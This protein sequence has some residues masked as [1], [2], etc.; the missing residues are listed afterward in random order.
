M[1]SFLHVKTVFKSSE[2]RSIEKL[3]EV[4][5]D[6]DSLCNIIKDIVGYELNEELVCGK[7]ILLKPNWVKHSNK[8]Y[9]E[10]CLRTNDNFIL[11]VLK[12]ILEL[13]PSKILIGDA[14]IQGCDWERMI[15]KKL[16][17]GVKELSNQFEIPVTIKD[18]RRRT[19]KVYENKP[20]SSVRPISD[21]VIFDLGTKSFLEPITVKDKSQFRVTNYDPDRMT[22]AHSMGVHKYCIAKDFFETDIV[23]S[24]PKVKTH[25][26][27]GITA[28]LKNLVGINGDKDFLPHHRIG[29]TKFGGDCYPGGS[30]LRYWAELSLDKANRRQGKRSFWFWQKISSLLWKLSLPGN[31]HQIAAGWHG[32]DTTWRMVKDLNLIAQFGKKDGTLSSEPIR[33]LYSL[34][35]GIVGGQGDGPLEPMP[36]PLGVV[37]FTDNSLMNDRAMS[38]LMGFEFE[39][40]PLLKKDDENS[41]N[42]DIKLDRAS[43][44]IGD[45]SKLAVKTIPPIGW[46]KYF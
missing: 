4:Y 11:A 8:E 16:M 35:D 13:E 33:K 45:L 25:Q 39:R 44:S 36:L 41:Q 24:L 2:S 12:T 7:S 21:Y 14:P 23:I 5:K 9:D 10:I 37:S 18:F 3:S 46:I 22:N 6:V 1:N 30:W 31:E 43:V 28:A 40:I 29:G 15:S 42:C 34:C 26:K 19:F 20:E 27:S 38:M 17:E 32:N